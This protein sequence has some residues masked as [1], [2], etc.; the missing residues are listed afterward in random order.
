MSSPRHPYQPFPVSLDP[1]PLHNE[2]LFC[3]ELDGKWIP[4]LLGAVSVLAAETTWK[5]DIERCTGEARNLLS[6]FASAKACQKTPVDGVEMDDCMSCCIRVNNGILQVFSCGEW[7]DIPGGNIAAIAGGSGNPVQSVDQP[8]AGQCRDF[9][10]KVLYGG[11]WLLPVPV[12]TGDVITVTN[13]LGATSGYVNDVYEWR[14]GDG[15]L[16]IAGGCLNGSAVTDGT[17][18]MPSAPRDAL[19]AFDGTNYYD[20]SDAANSLPVTITIPSGIT[21]G[22]LFFLVNNDSIAGAGDLQFNVSICKASSSVPRFTHTFDLRTGLH[23]LSIASS[24]AVAPLASYVPGTGVTVNNPSAVT[25]QG[26]LAVGMAT[27]RTLSNVVIRWTGSND[28]SGFGEHGIFNMSG[29]DPFSSTTLE[30]FPTS[31]TPAI[32]ET[33]ALT[34]DCDAFRINNS[35]DHAGDNATIVLI[36]VTADGADPF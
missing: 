11:R 7:Q 30:S 16:F 32:D 24:G 36:Q 4:Y 26:I 35:A 10:A 19:I 14:C 12:S 15:L 1:V 31:A 25:G 2:G 22:N 18:P 6:V 33:A 27:P 21:N 29:P 17:N 3:L 8:S 5:S 28:S 34:L 9:M 13:A 20:C 23:G